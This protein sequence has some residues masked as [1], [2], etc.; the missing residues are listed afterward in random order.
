MVEELEEVTNANADLARTLLSASNKSSGLREELGV[1]NSSPPPL[2]LSG[3][4]ATLT[5]Y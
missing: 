3:H 1:L 5:P 2:V 4:A